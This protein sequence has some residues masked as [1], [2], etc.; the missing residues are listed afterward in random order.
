MHPILE[1]PHIEE[2][3]DLRVASLAS[4]VAEPEFACAPQGEPLLAGHK[5]HWGAEPPQDATAPTLLTRMGMGCQGQKH[6]GSVMS[7]FFMN[8]PIR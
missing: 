6:V 1:C 8:V 5:S 3:I 4:N 2:R 7:R